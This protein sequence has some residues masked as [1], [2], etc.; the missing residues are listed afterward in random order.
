LETQL[1][2]FVNKKNN[3]FDLFIFEM[4]LIDIRI[5]FEKLLLFN[6]QPTFEYDQKIPLAHLEL[7]ALWGCPIFLALAEIW[8]CGVPDVMAQAARAEMF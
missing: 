7:A 3:T 5:V 6:A 8:A 2:F 4:V 1:I